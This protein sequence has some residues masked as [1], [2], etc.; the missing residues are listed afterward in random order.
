MR[1]ADVFS[2]DQKVRGL[3]PTC[4]VIGVAGLSRVAGLGHRVVRRGPLS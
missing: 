3:L 1:I 4:Y 2:S